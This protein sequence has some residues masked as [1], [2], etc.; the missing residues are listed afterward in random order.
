MFK[1]KL[2][3]S[4]RFKF[5]IV[6]SLVLFLSTF[7]LS[8]VIALNER[9]M[10]RHAL[11]TK[12]QG[13]ASYL[14]KIS[15]DSLIME[16]RIQL[17]LFVNEANKDDD[18]IYTII[19][20]AKG[21]ILTT[22]YA[23]INY[24]QTRLKAVL[25]GLS[26]DS[27]LQ[28]I[29]TAI[30]KDETATEFSTPIL[31][32]A[33]TI[34]T[35]T[36]AMS[37]YQIRR[38]TA[39]TILFVF[40][41]NA[42]GAF[43][44][45]IVLFIVSR[46]II[47]DPIAE[48]ANAASHLA[49]RELST[50]VKVKTTGEIQNLVDS[51]NQMAE[52]LE[53]TTVSKDYIDNIIKS[54]IDTLIVVSPKGKIL[55]LN[56]AACTLL[57]YEEKELIGQPIETI[58]EKRDCPK[59]AD[60]VA[61]GSASNIETSYIAKDRK[62]PVLFSAS[63]M[64]D[65]DNIIQGIVC[66]A[67]D[68]TKHKALE[69]QLIHAQKMETVGTLAGGVAHDFNNVLTAIIGYGH[70]LSMQMKDDDPLKHNVSQI[71]VSADRAANLTRE[72]LSFSRKQIVTLHPVNLNELINKAG[73]LLLRLLGDDIELKEIL[74]DKKLI[75]M[76][77][78]AYIEQVLM[79]LCTNAR[80]AMLGG[81]L[82]TIATELVE[83][84]KEFNSAH[85]YGKEGKYALISVTDTG[86]GMDEKIKQRIFEPFFTTKEVGKGTGLGLSTVYGVI[87]QHN[88]YINCYTE[89]GKGTTF[90]IYLPLTESAVNEMQL[91]EDVAMT[92]GT[93]TVLIADDNEE[94]RQFM[95]SILKK[96][97]YKVITSID[98]EDAIKKF[99]ENKDKIQLLLLDVVMPKKN[100]REAYEEIQLIK[101]DIKALFTS[102]YTANVIHKKG[103]IEEGLNFISKP[104]SPKELL[105]KVRE[106]LDKK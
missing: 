3:K 37:E 51:F 24:H 21:N 90:K 1:E 22:Q 78:N 70:L 18:I 81:G 45:G 6:I 39:K 52:N 82:L 26:R 91:S 11:M 103:V 56:T 49:K 10:L 58:F 73:E 12:G 79:N 71:L 105:N 76:G 92:G 9:K 33:N 30:K 23:S 19:K 97:G 94:V 59:L 106:I 40:L 32:G 80:D 8:T 61:N 85:G 55:R 77:D 84:D 17:D 75:V 72:L 36:I 88:G 43:V 57:G 46:K 99:T 68:I 69:A 53:K 35:V 44:L 2:R 96:F 60:I 4:I 86:I 27:E 31:S 41:L 28:D 67:Q 98:G 42:I 50:R 74:T 65:S 54:M 29:I 13:L 64:Y 5:L 16:D 102:G 47:L 104:S 25:S 63:A 93:E 101:P 87:K 38:Q 89:I 15:P 100:G 83:I 7:V 14:A 20:D 34:G 66:M 48:L 62:I 95:E